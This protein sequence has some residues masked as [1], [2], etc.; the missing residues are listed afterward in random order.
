MK[1]DDKQKNQLIGSILIA[2][3]IGNPD[4]GPEK[5]RNPSKMKTVNGECKQKRNLFLRLYW[6]VGSSLHQNHDCISK[7]KKRNRVL[8]AFLSEKRMEK[9]AISETC[10]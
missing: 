1:V 3:V 6:L 10:L 9:N 8:Q 7:K 4:F 5:T 2:T